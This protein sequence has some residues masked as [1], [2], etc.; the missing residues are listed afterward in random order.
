[1]RD[2]IFSGNSI[3]VSEWWENVV[4]SSKSQSLN[5]WVTPQQIHVHKML[6]YNNDLEC[7]SQCYWEELSIPY[8]LHKINYLAKH[9]LIRVTTLIKKQLPFLYGWAHYRGHIE[10][11][12][13]VTFH[14]RPAILQRGL[15]LVCE[16]TTLPTYTTGFPVT[17]TFRVA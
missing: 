7:C 1:M 14:S 13:T 11:W 3:S 17:N 9:S 2:H 5:H 4:P 6:V 16:V 12:L 8:T 10:Y 15:M